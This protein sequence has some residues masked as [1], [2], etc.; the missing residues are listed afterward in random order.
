MKRITIEEFFQVDGPGRPC[1]IATTEELIE[2]ANRYKFRLTYTRLV[3]ETA[4][5]HVFAET[6]AAARELANKVSEV[7]NGGMKVYDSEDTPVEFSEKKYGSVTLLEIKR[8]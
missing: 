3:T 8:P 6:E 1:I 5:T 4:V 2:M 7:M